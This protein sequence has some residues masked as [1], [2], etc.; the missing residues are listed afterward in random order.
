MDQLAPIPRLDTNYGWREVA[1]EPV[2][3]PLVPV[4][5]ISPRILDRA[6]YHAW[7]LPGTLSRSWVRA[8]VAVRLARV[9]ENLPVDYG[10]VVWD[11]YRPL[12]V[13]SALF[14]T[15][16]D[17]LMAVHPDLPADALE[18]AAARYVTP[19]SRSAVAPPPHLTGG[20]IDLTLGSSDGTER[21]LG[22]AFDAFV[23]E[24]TT[25]AFE[26]SESEIRDLRRLLYWSMRAQGFTNYSEEW[27][28]FDFGDQF[29]GLV[30]DQPAIYGPAPHPE[31]AGAS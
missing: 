23:P 25:R 19:P 9:V 2:E 16:L 8:G 15:Y 7:G 29:W 12:A 24:A 10:L 1:I 31:S 20:A 18:D 17:E 6:Q 28:H 3:E 14:H 4:A 21:D 11:A 5:G 27:W 22:T 30:T 13:Q 26:E